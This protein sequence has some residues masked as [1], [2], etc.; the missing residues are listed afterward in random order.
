M[1]QPPLNSM[2]VDV[3]LMDLCAADT[4]ADKQSS[5][6]FR[7]VVSSVVITGYVMMTMGQS[8]ASSVAPSNGD[9]ELGYMK[10]VGKHQI[11]PMAMTDCDEKN[12]D[13]ATDSVGHSP[14]S[15]P[16]K[17][18]RGESDDTVVGTTIPRSSGLTDCI[19][20]DVLEIDETQDI[21]PFHNK[22]V[23][24]AVGDI[25]TGEGGHPDHRSEQSDDDESPEVR[26]KKDDLL[27][28]T[29]E[30][31]SNV[32]RENITATDVALTV[33]PLALALLVGYGVKFNLWG[34]LLGETRL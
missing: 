20:D 17:K 32:M 18:G 30:F 25:E 6:W 9:V 5:F 29:D 7:R 15:T 26:A 21:H 14:D 12:D 33:V 27:K 2:L 16:E 31:I 11:V 8:Y 24:S 23:P 1:Q 4:L 34:E 28:K 10:P 3:S 22:I 19:V 13:G